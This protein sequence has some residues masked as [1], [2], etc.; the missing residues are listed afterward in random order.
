MDT[1]FFRHCFSI[2]WSKTA[3]IVVLGLACSGTA[4]QAQ[5]NYRYVVKHLEHYDDKLLHYGFFFAMPVTRFSVT[6]SPAFMTAADSAYRIESPNRANFRVGF[7][8]N[9]FLNDRFDF[10]V[11]PSVTLAN[12]EVNYTYPGGTQ[13][14][15]RREST[16]VDVPLLL[17]YKS[18]RRNNSRMYVLAGAAFS[19]ETN[20]RRKALLTTSSLSTR[21]VDVAVEYGVG[22]EHFFEF[23]KFAPELRFSHGLLNLYQPTKNLSGIGIS[24]LTTHTVTLILNFE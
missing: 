22:Y 21:T 15:E 2:H 9:S 19:L 3:L 20:V 13:R 10:R 24:R 1:S 11:T 14:I 4:A 8:L 18:E 16:W 7:V 5:S 6:H 12:R 23:F 17:K